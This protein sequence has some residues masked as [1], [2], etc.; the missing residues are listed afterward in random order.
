MPA[1]SRPNGSAGCTIRSTIVP[2]RALPAAACVGEA[3]G[4]QPDR[5]ACSPIARP[6][7]SKRAASAPPRPATTKPGRPTREPAPLAGRD[8]A[9]RGDRCGGWFGRRWQHR[10]AAAPVE[11]KAEIKTALDA[12]PVQTDIVTVDVSGGGRSVV[13]RDADGAARRGGRPAQQAQRHVP[14][15]HAQ[16]RQCGARRRRRRAAAR[17]RADRA[18][19]AATTIPARSCRSTCRA[20]TSSWRRIFSGWLY[21]ERPGAE[22]RTAPDLRCLGQELRDDLPAKAARI[23]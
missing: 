9:R 17:L 3:G 7:R 20:A 8:G 15:Y 6:V 21:K 14:R 10:Q 18:V 13:R 1:A 11:Q 16:A 19:G 5:H 23:R 22:R 4:A 2:D 12:E